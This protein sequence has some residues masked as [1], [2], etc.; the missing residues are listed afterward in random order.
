M[1][2]WQGIDTFAYAWAIAGGGLVLGIIRQVSGRL[3]PGIVAHSMF[4]AIALI[5]FALLN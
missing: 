4:N 3:G 5:V 2:N 1:I